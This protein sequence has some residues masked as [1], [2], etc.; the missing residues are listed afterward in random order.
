[1]DNVPAVQPSAGRSALPSLRIARLPS[2]DHC[3]RAVQPA[4]PRR[5]RRAQPHLHRHPRARGADARARSPHHGRAAYGPGTS[6]PDAA[7]SLLWSWITGGT[8]APSAPNIAQARSLLA[9]AGLARQRR[10]RRPRQGRCPAAATHGDLCR[11][12]APTRAAAG[13][14]GAGDVGAC[15]RQGRPASA[16]R[17]RT[18]QAPATS[19][20]FDIDC[21]WRQPG[22]EPTLAGR[23]A[24]RAPRPARGGP[25]N[26]AHWCDPDI[27]P[28]AGHGR[29]PAASAVAGMAR[30]AR[31]DGEPASRP[32]SSPRR[33][34]RCRR[35]TPATTTRPIL[36]VR[37]S[38]SPS[39]AGASVPAPRSP[40]IGDVIGWLAA[41]QARCRRSRPSWPRWCSCS[42]CTCCPGDP[43]AAMI[44]DRD[45]DAATRAALRRSWGTDGPPR[46]HR[47]L[48]RRR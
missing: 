37:G 15:R 1:M 35:C 9:A 17:S 19:G 2:N 33:P 31:P 40:A 29:R 23:G 6:V 47:A 36:P 3:L 48:S 4:Q 24:G 5:Q 43:L 25:L 45:I 12:R 8:I 30:G 38:G 27:R 42:W 39:G 26:V 13:H 20:Q 46:Q 14:P 41:P 32:P 44:G 7:Q 21:D 16:R 28:A 11:V 22:P 18:G 10:R 34:M